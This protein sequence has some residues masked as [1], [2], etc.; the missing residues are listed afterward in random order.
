M[1]TLDALQEALQSLPDGARVPIRYVLPHSHHQERL[2]VVT[3]GRTWFAMQRYE[4]RRESG[5]WSATKSP[6]P[7]A[8][9]PT[10][11]KRVRYLLAGNMP[12]NVQQVTPSLVR[13]YFDIPYQID[14]VAG[15]KYVGAG[16]VVD[17]A[18]GIVMVDRNTVPVGLGDVRVEFAS[19]VEVH[20]N[21]AATLLQSYC[22]PAAPR[23]QP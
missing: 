2:A 15:L 10:L 18:L 21:P 20:G 4:L 23:L 9:P 19:T 22:N 8:P 5:L 6:P 7:P 14:G 3:L 13:V 17:A 12:P 11:P 16:V 1:P